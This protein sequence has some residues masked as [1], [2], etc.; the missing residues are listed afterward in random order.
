MEDK[1]A[2]VAP[3]ESAVLEEEKP[4]TEEPAAPETAAEEP[5]TT[6]IEEESVAPEEEEKSQPEEKK[7]SLE[8]QLE[9]MKGNYLRSLAELENY[10]K[11]M[12]REMNEVREST[13]HRALTEV[14]GIY[15]LLQMAVDSART[16]QDVASL[17]QGVEMTFGELKR[18]LNGLGVEAVDALGQT[19]DPACH[20]AVGM[21][22]SDEV[23]EGTVLRQWKPG[24]RIG[25]KLVRP[26]VVV[27][28]KGP[29]KPEPA[30]AP[31]EEAASETEEK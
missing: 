19:F 17:R 26:A 20:Q 22:A 14:L 5:A 21:E 3:E 13:R 9:E 16:A 23:P 18:T 7:P 15:D 31:G 8:E 4:R 29:E 12:A 2:K 24:F 10:R 6:D 1:E 25:G 30:A 11:R 28:S 27:V